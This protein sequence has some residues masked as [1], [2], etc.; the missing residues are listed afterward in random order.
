MRQFKITAAILDRLG[1]CTR[2]HERFALLFPRGLVLT[3]DQ[4]VNFERIAPAIEAEGCLGNDAFSP[5][6][7]I[8]DLFWL[9]A[10]VG[11]TWRPCRVTF[12]D[13]YNDMAGRSTLFY[14]CG[15]LADAVGCYHKHRR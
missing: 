2:G 13:W 7:D 3:D 6:H 14:V 12:H 9:A 15:L 11:D 4:V 10:T 1:A 8:T 5:S